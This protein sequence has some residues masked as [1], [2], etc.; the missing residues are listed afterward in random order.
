MQAYAT[1]LLIAA[2]AGWLLWRWSRRKISGNCCG[3]VECPAAKQMVK[4][5]ERAGR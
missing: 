1:Y 3:E 2:A 5:L 4:N